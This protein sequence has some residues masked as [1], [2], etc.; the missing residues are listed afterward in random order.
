MK[1]YFVRGKTRTRAAENDEF[2]WE[3]NPCTAREV[4]ETEEEWDIGVLDHAGNPIM[5]RE[6]KEPIGFI[7]DYSNL[8]D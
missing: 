3:G 5:A 4:I 8:R 1:Q 7:R 6:M 2:W